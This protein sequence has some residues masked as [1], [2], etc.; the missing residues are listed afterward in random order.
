M[1]PRNTVIADLEKGILEGAE[2]SADLKKFA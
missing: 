1:T 2:N